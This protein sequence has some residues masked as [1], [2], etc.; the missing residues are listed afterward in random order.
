[1]WYLIEQYIWF[2]AAIFIIGI[3]VGWLTT[4]SYGNAK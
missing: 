2:I 3:L 1:M 4:E